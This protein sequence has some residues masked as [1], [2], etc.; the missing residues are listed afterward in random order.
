MIDAEARRIM[1]DVIDARDNINR[2]AAAILEDRQS[3]FGSVSLPIPRFVPSELG[4]LRSISWLYVH[5][6]EAGKPSVQFLAEQLPVLTPGAPGDAVNH[7]RMI[8]R[9]RTLLQHNLGGGATQGLQIQLDCEAWFQRMC[10]TPVPDTADDWDRCLVGLLSEALLFLG[11]MLA[12]IRAIERDAAREGLLEQWRFRRKRYH[13]PHTFDELIALVASDMGREH[14]DV[15]L[16]RKRFYEKWTRELQLLR[17]DYDFAV[18]ARK[19]IEHALLVETTR[20]LPI[21]GDDIMQVFGV[22]PGPKVGQYLEW[23][24]E[25]YIA[26]PCGREELLKRL[27]GR[28]TA[29]DRVSVV[30]NA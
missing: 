4:F 3:V 7:P 9:I 21:T 15:A 2:V 12:C 1:Y 25:I 29:S 20:V 28:A 5:Y 13:P 18:E 24:R 16:L 23:A 8:Q 27:A 22:P 19:L 10:G 26:E 14:L 11:Q 30:P 17:G 6:H